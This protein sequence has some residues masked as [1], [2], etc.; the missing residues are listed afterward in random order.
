M[1]SDRAPADGKRQLPLAQNTVL[2]ALGRTPNT[3]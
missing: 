3:F 1:S 2:F